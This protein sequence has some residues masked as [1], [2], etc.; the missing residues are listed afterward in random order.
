MNAEVIKYDQKTN[1]SEKHPAK[2]P[3][4]IPVNCEGCGACVNS[5]RNGGLRMTE[6]NVEG[7]FVPWLAEPRNCIG[8][9]MCAQA[10]V[11]GA[12]SMTG[13]VEMAS[14]RF[15]DKKPEIPLEEII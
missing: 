10:C 12:I 1:K 11:M 5:C 2:I 8:C 13:Y 14:K 15:R 3:W 7:V 6:T 9:G 4:V